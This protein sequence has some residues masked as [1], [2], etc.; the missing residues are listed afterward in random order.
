[1][2]DSIFNRFKSRNRDGDHALGDVSHRTDQ[3]RIIVHYHGAELLTIAYRLGKKEGFL[4]K[5]KRA[6]VKRRRPLHDPY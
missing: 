4:A 3:A 6:L 5:I 2:Y 1:M